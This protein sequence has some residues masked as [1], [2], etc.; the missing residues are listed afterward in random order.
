MALSGRLAQRSSAQTSVPSAFKFRRGIVRA[1]GDARSAG[2]EFGVL[3]R[4]GLPD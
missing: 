2:P 4:D 1:S 3:F